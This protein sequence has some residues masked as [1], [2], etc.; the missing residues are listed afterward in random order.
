MN[1]NKKLTINKILTSF[2][3]KILLLSVLLLG[4]VIPSLAQEHESIITGVVKDELT[5]E[6]LIGASVLVKGSSIGTTTDI[7]GK[8]K[9][10]TPIS[11]KILVISYLGY[12]KKEVNITH[13]TNLHIS[14][15]AENTVMDEVVVVGYDT[16]KKES[17]VGAI[18]QTNGDE[19][20]MNR[21]ST[22]L[23]NS[24]VGLVSGLSS[25]QTSGQ[26][27]ENAAEIFIRGKASWVDNSP[28]FLVDGIERD[29][30]DIDP[31]EIES[32]SVLKDASATAVFGT[33]GANGVILITT[34]QGE[35][36]KPKFSFSTNFS[37][38]QPIS[39]FYMADRVEVMEMKNQAL[40]NDKIYD[41]NAYYSQQD[42]N[43]WAHQ[44]NPDLYPDVDWYNELVKDYGV[45]SNYNFN[46]SGGSKRINYFVSLGYS[47]DGDIFKT[48]PNPY[49]DPSFSYEKYNYRT[50]FKVKLTNST[51]IKIGL[52][53]SMSFKNQAAYGS[54]SDDDWAKSDFFK[55]VYYKAPTY[56]YPIQYSDGNLGDDGGGSNPY[57]LLNYSGAHKNR[58]NTQA[59]DIQLEQKLDFIT[60]G[61]SLTGKLSYNTSFDYKQTIS[62]KSGRNTGFNVPTYLYTPTDT[63]RFP[64]DNYVVGPV[65]VGN[66]SLGAYKRN[67]YYEAALRYSRKF[68]KHTVS[69][70]GLFMRSENISRISWPA[71]EESWIGRAT[72]DYDQRYFIEMNGA[73]NGS[74]KFAPGLRFGFFPS[75][76]GGWM[77]SN[78]KFFKNSSLSDQ[79]N[80]FKI[81]ASYGEVG[82][83]KGVNRWTYLELYERGSDVYFGTPPSKF[84]TNK[85]GRAAN[86]NAT[87]ERAL[88]ANIGVELEMFSHLTLI[89]DVFNEHR[90]SILMERKTIPPWFGLDNP[91]ENIGETKSR[92]FEMTMGWNQNIRK[93]FNINAKAI[94]SFSQNRVVFR[95][96]P[97]KTPD[98]LK[99]AGKPIGSDY[100]LKT[101]GLYQD[102]DD[103]YNSPGSIWGQENRIPGDQKYVDYN[104]DGIIDD[105]DKVVAEYQDYPMLSYSLQ[106]GFTYKGIM[107]TSLFTG[108]SGVQKSVPD[109]L[110][111]EFTSA[112]YEQANPHNLNAWTPTNTD[113]NVPILRSNNTTRLHNQQ[114]S[115]YQF[116]NANYL[117]LQR[118]ELSYMIRSK[119]MKKTMGIGSILVYVGGN[120]LFTLTKMDKRF[121][122]EAATLSSYPL[123][124]SYNTG[125][126]VKF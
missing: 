108:A 112:D 25:I 67:L 114:Y 62:N 45:T 113:T 85:E 9:L 111:Y 73:Y 123:I 6:T 16:Q 125:L 100:T 86:P 31:N 94:T 54:S 91:Y 36:G 26:P 11:S 51:N 64:S 76:A 20:L 109:A 105:L 93:D 124:R 39:D 29:Y 23:T 119:R 2:S 107:L 30:E 32:I 27:G 58:K 13:K 87:W 7:D 70:L 71:Y 77:V 96:D 80:L 60:K 121:D 21:G 47:N 117:R 78:E 81:R 97:A 12:K 38:K 75:F 46:V 4:F 34:K 122:P 69:G 59:S 79:I 110:L 104:G 33:K 37:F 103:V 120:N 89:V 19:L 84:Y 35:E 102:W 49:Y 50:N 118:V 106:L 48:E 8:F 61:L 115:D 3:I 56:V 72:Y 82:Y 43:N 5:G 66:E 22:S 116:Q 55:L 41:P 90:S 10:M 18:V 40:R 99:D 14:L 98:Y 95:D 52:A 53:G 17:V 65:T 24:L 83:D 126:T 88:K 28:L 42:I 44:V 92:G 57:L 74:E 15:K 68:G 63:L 1:D 101:D